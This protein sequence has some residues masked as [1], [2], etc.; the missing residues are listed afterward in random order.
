MQR[1]VPDPESNGGR[2]YSV[3]E[4]ADFLG[5]PPATIYA[6][7]GAGKGPRGIRVGRWTTVPGSRC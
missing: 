7:R 5:V 3:A 6:W 4:L 2:L 1:D